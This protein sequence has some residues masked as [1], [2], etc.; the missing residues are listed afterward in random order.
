MWRLTQD[1]ALA[2]GI[3]LAK[4][5]KARESKCD[6][7]GESM[8]SQHISVCQLPPPEREYR[9]DSDRLWRFDFAWPGCLVAAEVE[10]GTRSGGRHSRHA[11]FEADCE[12]YNAAMLAGWRVFR[13][14]TEQVRI[15]YAIE[16]M[17]GALGCGQ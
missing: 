3:V 4:R 1:Q 2:I 16:I 12:K 8:L 7:V 10:G 9:F 13:F 17:K 6:S 11:G 15:G 5:R 14:T